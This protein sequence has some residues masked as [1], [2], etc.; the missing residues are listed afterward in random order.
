MTYI[1]NLKEAMKNVK[2]AGKILW[3][4]IIVQFAIV[5]KG[6]NMRKEAMHLHQNAMVNFFIIF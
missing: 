5:R 6:L 1:S 2:D 4:I 3:Q